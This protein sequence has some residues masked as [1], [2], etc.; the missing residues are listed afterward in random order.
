MIVHILHT[1]N[2]LDSIISGLLKEFGITHVQFNILK[3]LEAEHPEPMS[4]GKVKEGLLFSNSDMTRLMD[5]LVKKDL[6]LRNVCP[7][8]R[9]QVDIEISDKGLNLLEKI[10]PELQNVLSNYFAEKVSEED[11]VFIA[12]MMKLIRN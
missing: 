1:A 5:R 3:V 7:N 12:N 10:N 6:I 2:W 4:V 11:A 9:R 8:N